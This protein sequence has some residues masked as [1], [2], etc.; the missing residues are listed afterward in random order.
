MVVSWDVSWDVPSGKHTSKYGES[1][2]F[3]GNSTINGPLSIAMLVHKRVPY[4]S[5]ENWLLEK[6][7]KQLILESRCPMKPKNQTSH[8]LFH[9]V[10]LIARRFICWDP[11]LGHTYNSTIQEEVHR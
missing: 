11:T 8:A 9:P 5:V 2:L 4:C 3:I 1:Q 6:Q 7:K 10:V